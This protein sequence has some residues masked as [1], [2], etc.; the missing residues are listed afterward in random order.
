[1]KTVCLFSPNVKNNAGPDAQCSVSV[2]SL[3]PTGVSLPSSLSIEIEEASTLAA[4]IYPSGAW[5]TLSWWSENASV[6]SV[7]QAG[8]VTGIGVKDKSLGKNE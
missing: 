6:A 7:D 3:D 4:M 8:C 2:L 5:S 1:M